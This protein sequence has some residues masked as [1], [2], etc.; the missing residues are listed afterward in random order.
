MLAIGFIPAFLI[1]CLLG[2][3]LVVAFTQPVLRGDFTLSHFVDLFRSQAA[4]ITA[5]NTIIFA[6]IT[7][8][9]AMVI[10]VPTAW[11]VERTDLRGKNVVSI[12]MILGVL[13][14]GFIVAMGWLLMFDPKIG[15][16]NRAIMDW[17]GLT[18][19][20]FDIVNIPGGER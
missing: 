2:T 8:V 5:Q 19:P 12:V 11:L 17:T 1:V 13:L 9:I 3:V 7:T 14:P 10:G 16:F 6:V 15:L 20:V 18:F 4:L